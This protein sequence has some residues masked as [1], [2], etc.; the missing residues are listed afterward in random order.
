MD[1]MFQKIRGVNVETSVLAKIAREQNKYIKCKNIV[2]LMILAI[3][4]VLHM[5]K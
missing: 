5:S 3:Y 4:L 1:L 2:F